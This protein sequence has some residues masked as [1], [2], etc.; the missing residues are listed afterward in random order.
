[1][2]QSISKKV[3]RFGKIGNILITILL[4]AGILVTALLAAGTIWLAALPRDAV[5]VRIADHAQIRIDGEYFA[6]LW[7]LLADG[8]SYSSG[9]EPSALLPDAEQSLV[10][11]ENQ[12]IGA[13]IPLFQYRFSSAI[14]RS[15][16]ETKVIEAAS[17]TSVYHSGDLIRVLV[18]GIVFLLSVLASLFTLKCLF[19][20]IAKCAS[21][22]SDGVVKKMRCFS[23]SL[24]PVAVFAFAAETLAQNFLSAGREAGIC[25]Q[26]GVVIAFF[27]AICLV[28][29]FRYG[30]ALQKESDET[31]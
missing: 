10:P 27:V 25:I 1:M 20:S 31:L 7:S 23:Y 14:I 16:G 17:D 8:F 18:A 21:P 24:I 3:N 4:I 9:D 30:V 12:E 5:E 6:K 26:W 19:K 2:N 29:V 22:F 13:E 11:P 15:E 28:T